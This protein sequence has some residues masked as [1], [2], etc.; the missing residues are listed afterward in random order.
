MFAISLHLP[1][2]LNQ[3]VKRSPSVWYVATWTFA[4]LAAFFPCSDFTNAHTALG[5]GSSKF[6]IGLFAQ[7]ISVAE[8]KR[9]L[10]QSSC[11]VHP[12]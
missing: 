4:L 7:F 10:R 2:K 9:R 5:E 3:H 11:F 8:K 1:A 12:P 6:V